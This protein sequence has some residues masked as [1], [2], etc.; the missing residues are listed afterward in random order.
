MTT[1][2]PT[3]PG[4]TTPGTTII[5]AHVHFTPPGMLDTIGRTGDEPYWQFIM[6]PD[7]KNQT[8]QSFVTA[9]RMIADM[10]AGGIDEVVLLAGYQQSA[11]GCREANDTVLALAERFPGRIIPFVS[12]SPADPGVLDELARCLD[13]GAAGV[14]EMNPYAQG[15]TLAGPELRRVAD[16]C[17]EQNIPLTLHMSEEV[18]RFY[19]GKSTPRL[20]DYYEFARSVPDLKLVL[21]HWGGGL[22][23]FEMM[24][25][26]A[27]QLAHVSYDTAASPL[28]YPTG[29]VFPVAEQILAPHKVLYGSDYPLRITHE[30]N[31]ADFVPFLEQIDALGLS[32]ERRE[33]ILS[34]NT[35][36][37]IDRSRP[38][39]RGSTTDAALA[40][41]VAA[42]RALADRLELPI[43]PFASVALVASRYPATKPVFERYGIPHTDSAV[44]VWEPIVQSAAARNIPAA[45]QAE[46]IDDLNDALGT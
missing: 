8:E 2:G 45:R 34:Q 41:E 44:P 26:V 27:E 7:E 15:C 6:T 14:G 16:A 20:G 11:R 5:D 13:R 33:R 3:T 9:E 39:R 25:L 19:F 30:Q 40:E 23:F 35:L 22:F 18:G 28:L 32:E 17:A 1:P 4:T 46:L 37:L 42:S 10:D 36:E 24:P 43:D 21:A 29:T 12:L 38:V 31:D